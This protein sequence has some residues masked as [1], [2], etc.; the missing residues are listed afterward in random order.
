M[1]Q[2]ALAP[3]SRAR[4][5][6]EQPSWSTARPPAE[7]PRDRAFRNADRGECSKGKTECRALSGCLA[8][9]HAAIAFHQL[10]SNRKTVPMTCLGR[11]G[12]AKQLGGELRR[13]TVSVVADLHFGDLFSTL[14]RDFDPPQLRARS[15]YRQ[16]ILQQIEQNAEAF[17]LI[18][19]H[20]MRSASGNVDDEALRTERCH[21]I[22]DMADDSRDV[23][24]MPAAAAVHGMGGYDGLVANPDRFG[25]QRVSGIRGLCAMRP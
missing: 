20:E 2:G 22:D 9:Q 24:W 11:R 10:T 4:P 13:Q 1:A 12:C 25:D 3:G 21:K 17:A 5:T 14:D 19:E 8:S 18:A 16:S 7:R 23:E 15:R 6:A